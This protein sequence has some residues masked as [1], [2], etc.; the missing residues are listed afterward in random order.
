V[1]KMKQR[2]L[3]RGV[4]LVLVGLMLS[5]LSC[6]SSKGRLSPV[7]VKSTIEKFFN[8]EPFYRP[9]KYT[10]SL[11]PTVTE[12]K[13]A[14]VSYTLSKDGQ[15][16]GVLGGGARSA[17]FVLSDDGQWYMTKASLNDT[18]DSPMRVT[19]GK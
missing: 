6:S 9:G 15:V 2:S 7:A 16:I 12:G 18:P 1:I 19:D 3:V 5:A 11:G 13:E 10:V 17:Y 4:M 8:T 14:T